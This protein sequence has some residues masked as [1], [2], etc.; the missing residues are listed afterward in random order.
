MLE[1]FSS[2]VMRGDIGIPESEV[3]LS[4][5]AALAHALTRRQSGWNEKRPPPVCCL[6]RADGFLWVPRYYDTRFWD[7]VEFWQWA[8]GAPHDFEVKVPL[9]PERGQDVSVPTMIDHLRRH[10]GGILVS[11]TGTGKTVSAYAIAA[12]FGRK[13]G[14]LFY[15]GH[16]EDNWLAH[17]GVVL[18]IPPKE[19]GIVR[20]DRCDLSKPVTLISIQTLLSRAAPPELGQQI[21]F[22]IADEVHRHGASKWHE[23]VGMFPARYRLGLSADPCRGDG[24]DD[25]VW[26]S[27]G[28]VGHTARRIRTAQAQAPLCVML[29]WSGSYTYE[30]YCRWKK[31]L[32]EWKP[33]KPDPMKYDKVLARDHARTVMIAQEIVNAARKGRQILV[34]SRLCDHLTQLRDLAAVNY[35]PARMEILASGLKK[36]AREEVLEKSDVIFAT[37]SMAR[38]ALNVPRLDTLFFATPPGDPLQPIGRLREKAEGLDRNPLMV[39]DCRENTQF[40]GRKAVRRADDYRRLGIKVLEVRRT[41]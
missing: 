2:L 4:E 29:S 5:E 1:T 24:L 10:A 37:Y 35:L 32:G 14:V 13:I 25:L 9:D 3:T 19:V 18:G 22:L 8:E 15:A 16:M 27:F 7:N 11:P 33:D 28:E 17:A 26:W 34:L 6:Q 23:I 21:G 41:A 36:R 31:I 30:S 39:V 20:E 38:D 12:A 40:S